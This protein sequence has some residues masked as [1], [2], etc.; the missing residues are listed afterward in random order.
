MQRIKK[1]AIVGGGFSGTMVA[2]NLLETA[3]AGTEVILIESRAEVGQGLAYSTQS[4]EHL[5]NVRAYN[6]SAFPDRPTHFFEFAQK[7][8]PQTTE[9][10]FVKRKIYGLYLQSN[11]EQAVAIAE[12]R[13]VKFSRIKDEAVS[14]ADGKI[15]LKSGESRE[16]DFLVLAM[17]NMRGPAMKIIESE[18]AGNGLYLHDPWQEN[19]IKA[20]AKNNDVLLI[21]TGLTAVDKILELLKQGHQGHIYAVSRHGLF[22]LPHLQVPT[23]GTASVAV[24]AKMLE[25]LH[26]VREKSK[27][28]PDWR[29]VVDGLRG[30]TQ[31]WW[32]SLPA[33]DQK[34]FLR[35]LQTYWDVHRH[36]MAPEI[37][38]KISAAQ[39]SGQTSVHAG[40]ILQA[41]KDGDQASVKVRLR[42]KEQIKDF[43]VSCIINCTG[44]E[45]KL[46]KV[47]SQLFD[48]LEKNGYVQSHQLGFGLLVDPSGR[49]IDQAGN[50]SNQIFTLGP[51]LKP[52]LMETVAVPELRV[53]AR[54]LAKVLVEQL[55]K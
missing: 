10:D 22:P 18:L 53:Q 1:I 26:E 29:S 44:P 35:H 21:G 48:S 7:L 40:R 15:V 47:E 50:I 51:V 5:L 13:S 25:T 38:A 36:R 8:E 49:L 30:S 16:I 33:K 54:D 24:T 45:I 52:Q 46:G 42:H 17:G 6:M 55:T 37:A 20:I 12:Q 39:K 9:Q 11:L 32:Q 27:A 31:K 14:F 23:A 28:A 34:M 19:K 4:E 41:V 2:V 3:P 43:K